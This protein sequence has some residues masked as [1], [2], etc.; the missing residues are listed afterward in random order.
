MN[1]VDRNEKVDMSPREWFIR[2]TCMT[3]AFGSAIL[4]AGGLFVVGMTALLPK[5][6]SQSYNVAICVGLAWLSGLFGLS[7]MAQWLNRGLLHT[8]GGLA[9][10]SRRNKQ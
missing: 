3:L 6:D 4:G 9:P 5:I 1:Q 8:F 7:P 10:L 2:M